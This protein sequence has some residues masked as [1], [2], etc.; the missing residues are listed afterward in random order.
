MLSI[1]EIDEKKQNRFT[2]IT[3]SIYFACRSTCKGWGRIEVNR[4]ESYKDI[5]TAKGKKLVNGVYKD[6]SWWERRNQKIL[7]RQSG[8]YH[9]GF[10]CNT[11]EYRDSRPQAEHKQKKSGA[12]DGLLAWSALS[13][14]KVRGRRRNALDKAEHVSS[15]GGN[16][17]SED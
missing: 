12:L 5:V 8:W 11:N 13:D 10:I 15:K 1:Y 4:W 6:L 17:G 2:R 16:N 14:K 9:M 3:E 7:R